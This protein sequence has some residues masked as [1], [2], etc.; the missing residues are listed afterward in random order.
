MNWYLQQ[1]F[2]LFYPM[3]E[4]YKKKQLTI[5]E[6]YHLYQWIRAYSALPFPKKDILQKGPRYARTAEKLDLLLDQLISQGE[7]AIISKKDGAGPAYVSWPTRPGGVDYIPY[8]PMDG[9]CN[10]FDN[11]RTTPYK[12][13]RDKK[14]TKGL[15]I[16][17]NIS[18]IKKRYR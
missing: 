17:V 8:A 5:Q 7:L 15:G 4:E 3:T 2:D 6:I 9:A 10:V 16:F 1:A 14:H 13:L 12:I 11:S 18:D